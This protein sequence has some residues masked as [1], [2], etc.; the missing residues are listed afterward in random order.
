MRNKSTGSS[1]L[2]FAGIGAALFALTGGVGKVTETVIK[3]IRFA[4]NGVS[5]RPLIAQPNTIEL[6]FKS[7]IFNDN[8]IKG[9]V[10]ELFGFVTFQGH[11]IAE[12][13]L[14]NSVE[15]LA[16]KKTE[17]DIILFIDISDRGLPASIRNIWRTGNFTGYLFLNGSMK[18]NFGKLDFKR[19]V[20]IR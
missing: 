2:I 9:V 12:Y 1:L 13:K 16:N 14:E 17:F 7:E 5:V 6:V 10:E 19:P 11:K 20:Q 8:F 15:F 4:I 3:N 18:T